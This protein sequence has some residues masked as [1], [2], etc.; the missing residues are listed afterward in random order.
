MRTPSQ[1]ERRRA[2]EAL[3]EADRHKDEFLTLLGHEL[4]N[5]LAPIRNALHLIRLGG[6]GMPEEALQ[7]YNLIERQVEHLA[8]LVDDLLDVTRINRGKI[9]L[10]R[11]CVDLAVVVARAVEGSRPLIDARRHRLE[12]V[13]PSAP[14]ALE[15]D[16]VRLAQVLGNLLNNAAKYTPE[17]GRSRL[18][19]EVTEGSGEAAAAPRLPSEVVVRVRDTGVGIPAALLPRV[20]DLF[21]QAERTQ[22]RAEGGL[23]SS[24]HKGKWLRRPLPTGRRSPPPGRF[25]GP[26]AS[27]G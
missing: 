11:E 22:D 21:T 4:R 16:P 24:T 20:F 15:A 18:T 26:P 8:R 7:T 2:E 6:Q 1:T 5:P 23:N 19:A 27:S 25:S 3:E 12:V 9:Q 17:G 14:V 13:L 10:R